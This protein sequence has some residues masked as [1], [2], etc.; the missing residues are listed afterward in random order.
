MI[1]SYRIN[2]KN[3]LDELATV[4]QKLEELTEKWEVDMGVAMNLSLCLEEALTNVIFYA[5]PEGKS[6]DIQVTVQLEG[7]SVSIGIEDEGKAFN[8]LTDSKDPD[9]EASVED[10]QIGG[11]GIHF[12]KQFMDKLDYQRINNKNQLVF[13]KKI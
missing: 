7:G 5:Y 8:P 11:L 9:L 4:S 1:D 10:R 6:G 2:I 3:E 12:I 13:S